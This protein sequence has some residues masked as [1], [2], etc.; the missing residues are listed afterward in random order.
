MTSTSRSWLG[1]PPPE[2]ETFISE[3]LE[4]VRQFDRTSLNNMTP[5]FYQHGYEQAMSSL[6][7]LLKILGRDPDVAEYDT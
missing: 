4:F 7:E 5:L 1:T 6:R 3:T 2:I